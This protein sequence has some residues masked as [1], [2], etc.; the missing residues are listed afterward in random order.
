MRTDKIQIT[1][2]DAFQ[3][4]QRWLGKIDKGTENHNIK[5]WYAI[6]GHIT[7]ALSLA[8][9]RPIAYGS[10]KTKQKTNKKT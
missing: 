5:Y 8:R 9:Q 2:R 6:K 7:Y 3:S 10:Q 1:S 4:R